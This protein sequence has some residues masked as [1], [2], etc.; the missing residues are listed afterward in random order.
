MSHENRIWSLGRNVK[1][2]KGGGAGRIK[3]QNFYREAGKVKE[4]EIK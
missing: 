1:A 3:N 2:K 4:G